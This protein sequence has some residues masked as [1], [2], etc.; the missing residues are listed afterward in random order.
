MSSSAFHF[1]AVA[2]SLRRIVDDDGQM[3]TQDDVHG[4]GLISSPSIFKR[5]LQDSG[6]TQAAFDTDGFFRTGDWIFMRAGKVF[7][8]GRI[9]VSSGTPFRPSNVC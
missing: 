8:D 3:V 2:E 1:P 9:K 6:A 5:Y 7:V 4:E